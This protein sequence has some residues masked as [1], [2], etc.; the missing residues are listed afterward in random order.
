MSITI[1]R[2]YFF[3]AKTLCQHS[4]HDTLIASQMKALMT[5][6]LE[7]T[8]K[9]RRHKEAAKNDCLFLVS[10][11]SYDTNANSWS[12]VKK[13]KEDISHAMIKRLFVLNPCCVANGKCNRVRT[14][15]NLKNWQIH[16]Y[17][18]D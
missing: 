14:K 16:S 13:L 5:R 10:D 15:L 12:N 1:P 2:N 18:C 3:Q 17:N 7:H 9:Q 8:K 4:D 6:S 11:M